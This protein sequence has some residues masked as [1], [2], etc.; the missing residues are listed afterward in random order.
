ME[1]FGD[2]LRRQGVKGTF[3]NG[4]KLSGNPLLQ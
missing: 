3:R 4:I 1:H 2:S